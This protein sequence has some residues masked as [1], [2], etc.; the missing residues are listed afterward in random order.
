MKLKSPIINQSSSEGI[1][2][3]N[4]HLIKP[5]LNSPVQGPYILMGVHVCADVVEVKWTDMAKGSQ[6]IIMPEKQSFSK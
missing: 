1:F 4:N 6:C 5:F 2:R 3:S